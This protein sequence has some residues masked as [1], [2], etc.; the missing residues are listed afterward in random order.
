VQVTDA[1][2]ICGGVL[3][4]QA[5]VRLGRSYLRACPACGSW[6]YFP[7]GDSA[8]QA[9]LHDSEEYFGHPYFSVRRGVTEAQRRRCRDV[10]ARIS[11]GVDIAALRGQRMLDIGCDTGTF[12][13]AAE[14]EAGIVPVGIDVAERAIAAC[15]DAGIEAYQATV[16]QA[17]PAL[18]GFPVVTA[19]DL[20]EHV[21]DPASFLR[22]VRPRVRPGG[23]VYVET[24]NILSTVYQF[25]RRLAQAT[26]GRPASLLERLFP[27]QHVQYFTP[28]S[29][30]GLAGRAGFEVL[31]LGARVLPAS[32]IAASLPALAAIG[33]LQLCDRMRGT[34]ILIWTVLRRP[35]E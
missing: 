25:G 3:R 7:R 23:V 27:P 24:P 13:K 14:A 11:I 28:D 20:I 35:S 26:R 1:C 5:A 30:R 19:I 34:E 12:L 29:L 18:A 8:E 2:V 22:A 10:F 16:E 31:A 21:P 32:A 9:A 6:T 4:E 33:A 17:P 15:R